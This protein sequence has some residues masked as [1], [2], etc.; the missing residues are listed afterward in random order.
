MKY[1]ATL[2]ISVLLFVG[3]NNENVTTIIGELIDE[4][5]E[6][7]RD[8]RLII[9][10]REA[11]G[12][13]LGDEFDAVKGLYGEPDSL[14][15]NFFSYREHG[16][17]GSVDGIGR[18]TGLFIRSPNNAKTEGDNGAGST[19]AS[20]QEEFGVSEDIRESEFEFIDTTSHWYWEQGIEFSVDADDIVD[21]IYVFAP[22]TEFTGSAMRQLQ[23]FIEND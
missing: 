23:A 5:E 1:L 13:K 12:I 7:G 3:C 19:L 11:A 6:E 20:V 22:L 16:I 4:P 15:H 2:L 10:G 14:E 8:V 9:P 21:N 17:S 18:V